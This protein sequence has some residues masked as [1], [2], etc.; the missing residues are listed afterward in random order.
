MLVGI[1]GAAGRRT[2]Y[3][4]SARSSTPCVLGCTQVQP[5]ASTA[6]NPITPEPIHGTPFVHPSRI[7]PS[8]PAVNPA[9]KIGATALSDWP[10]AK[11]THFFRNQAFGYFGT[12][13]CL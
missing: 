10:S 13:A 8:V 9:C 7:V 4:S 5:S 2:R 3:G 12:P 11:V 1:R 6:R